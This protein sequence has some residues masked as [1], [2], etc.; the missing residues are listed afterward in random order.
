MATLKA[1]CIDGLDYLVDKLNGIFAKKEDVKIETVKVNNSPLT[2]DGSKA[3]NIDL[4]NYALKSDI[5]TVYKY[6]GSVETYSAL[7]TSDQA[8]GDTYNIIQADPSHDILAGDNVV[9][10]GSEWDKLGGSFDGSLYATKEEL[11]NK[12][13]KVSGKQLSTEDYTTA[14]KNKLA[15]LTNY[16]HPTGDGNMHVPANGTSNAGKVLTASK[17]AGV[18]TWEDAGANIE[19]ITTQEIDALFE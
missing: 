8:V 19:E 12:V 11:N 13:D 15:G 10:T 1:L 16:T 14:E 17:I 18:Y 6:K 5:T 4:T 2:P 7:P 9:W 3:V